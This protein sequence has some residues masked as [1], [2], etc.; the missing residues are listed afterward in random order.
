MRSRFKSSIISCEFDPSARVIAAASFDGTCKILSAYNSSVDPTEVDG[1]FA[2]VDDFGAEVAVFK[3]QFWLNH[4]TWDPSGLGI[5][6]C[7]HD[8][9]LQF[10]DLSSGKK[11]KVTKYLHKGLPFVKG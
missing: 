7:S 10:A 2:G 9:T 1:P 4:V 6:Y 11:G 5:C 8:G 3:C